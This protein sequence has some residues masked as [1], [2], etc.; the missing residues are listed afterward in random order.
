MDLGKAIIRC[1]ECGTNNRVPKEK[2]KD[3]PLCGKCGQTLHPE[4]IIVKCSECGA[5]NR[6]FK[7]LIKDQG[8]CGKCQASL[9]TVPFYDYVVET[10]DRTFDKEV[11]SFPGPVLSEFYSDTCGYC[12]LLTPILQQLAKEYMGRLKITK[13]NIDRNPATASRYQIMSTPNMILFNNG[14]EVH[15]MAGALQKHELENHLRP[16]L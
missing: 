11:L 7:A 3:K 14:R 5:K 16:F 15:K 9:K 4:T 1:S 10:T 2:L 6:V 8:K 12:H 13:L